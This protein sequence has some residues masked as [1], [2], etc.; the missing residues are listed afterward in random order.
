MSVFSAF[1][2][3][4]SFSNPACLSV[5]YGI[6]N[7][8]ACKN[9]PFLFPKSFL[10]AAKAVVVAAVTARVAASVI[11]MIN[12]LLDLMRINSC[13]Y[14]AAEFSLPVVNNN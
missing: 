10:P 13:L 8:D 6:S 12:F 5:W 3:R 14:F 11:D 7:S 1:S 4:G 2:P 9:L